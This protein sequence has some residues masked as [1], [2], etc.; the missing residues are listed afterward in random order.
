MREYEA[1]DCSWRSHIVFMGP[2]ARSG[3]LDILPIKTKKQFSP[4]DELQI[5]L[6]I[7]LIAYNSALEKSNIVAIKPPFIMAK[8]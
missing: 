4:K 7:S 1:A 2:W 3:T 5:G 8:P 6:E